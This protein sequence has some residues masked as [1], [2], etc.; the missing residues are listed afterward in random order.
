MIKKLISLVC[1]AALAFTMTATAFADSDVEYKEV[2]RDN[3]KS[4]LL[5][6][7]SIATGY[8]LE[9]YVEGDNYSA[10]NYGSKLAE[11]YSITE[12]GYRNFAINGQTSEQL[13]EKIESGTYD[14]SLACEVVSISIGGNDLLTL[15]IDM[16]SKIDFS[17]VLTGEVDLTDL[18]V[19]EMP[20]EVEKLS[21][22][23]DENIIKFG[24][25]LTEIIK[26]INK[27]NPDTNII[28]QT[29]YNPMNTGIDTIDDLYQE[30]ITALNTV[31]S[32]QDNCIVADV[33]TIFS[34]S[35]QKLVQ[36]DMT[37][38][39]DEGHKLIFDVLDEKILECEFSDTIEIQKTT[40][41]TNK[42][43]SQLKFYII[44]L[45]CFSG[46][47]VVTVLISVVVK[48]RKKNQ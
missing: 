20:E 40:V 45:A 38:P 48:I 16:L 37:H 23:A 41:E 13:L 33:N 5:L 1:T 43:K 26:L 47:I 36:K 10:D 3:P 8:G 39:N 18:L 7:D 15:L 2:P 6:G 30:K 29:L 42:P 19:N 17:V 35:D 34:S 4:L 46:L 32:S 25:N 21:K 28:I 31:I 22:G 12:D 24:E 44:A 11:K 14:K 9:G 27:K